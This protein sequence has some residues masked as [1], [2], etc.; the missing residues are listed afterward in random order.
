MMKS[1]KPLHH[2]VA[3]IR[4]ERQINKIAIISLND[5]NPTRESGT[6]I[7]VALSIPERVAAAKYLLTVV[8]PP[9]AL[10]MD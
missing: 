2:T 5:G 4:T 8:A 7:N 6:T 10:I 3:D 1:C 9:G